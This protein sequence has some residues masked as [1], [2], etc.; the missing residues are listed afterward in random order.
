M[1]YERNIFLLST[2]NM[3]GFV[4]I[5]KRECFSDRGEMGSG[6]FER[7]RNLSSK[8]GEARSSSRL[9]AII[10]KYL[11]GPDVIVFLVLTSKMNRN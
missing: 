5:G 8:K 4:Q 10:R 1:N 9:K 2:N 11:E 3:D 7:K 6:E